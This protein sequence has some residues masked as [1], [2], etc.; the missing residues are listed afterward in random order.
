MQ[1]I[2]RARR[3]GCPYPIV[4]FYEY[5][6]PGSFDSRQLERTIGKAIPEFTA[7][8]N[9]H[10]FCQMEGGDD[11]TVNID[12]WVLRSDGTLALSGSFE[13]LLYERIEKLTP[14]LLMKR[15]VRMITGEEIEVV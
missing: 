12:N 5:L 2:G 11:F 14:H 6:N 1:A 13:P 8:L 7:H 15:L 9:R 10:V 3:I 4:Y